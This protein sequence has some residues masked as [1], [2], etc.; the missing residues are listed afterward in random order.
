MLVASLSAA[1]KY[2]S[3]LPVNLHTLPNCAQPKP[4]KPS[5]LEKLASND[6]ETFRKAPSTRTFPDVC[7]T[8]LSQTE[9]MPTAV[10]E[11][12]TAWLSP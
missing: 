10:L 9:N 7:L 6:R 1:T 8:S 3:A 12:I 2:S 5:G 11:E 4:R